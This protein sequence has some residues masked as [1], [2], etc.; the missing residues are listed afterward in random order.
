MADK[1]SDNDM[2]A[3][4]SDFEKS[5]GQSKSSVAQRMSHNSV[6]GLNQA[7][8]LDLMR[9]TQNTSKMAQ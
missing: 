6:I 3:A 2:S 1:R 8:R 4:I 7:Q 9:Q 5:I